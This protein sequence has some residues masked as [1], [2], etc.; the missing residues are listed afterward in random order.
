MHEYFTLATRM[1]EPI[2]CFEPYNEGDDI[3]EYFECVELFLRCTKSQV[4]GAPYK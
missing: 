4:S 1:T 2:A 3:E